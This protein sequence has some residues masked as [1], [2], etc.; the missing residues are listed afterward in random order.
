MKVI[1][2]GNTYEIF[3]DTLCTYDSLPP[4][5]YIA[6]FSEFKGFYLKKCGDIE[7][8]ENK[9]Y[10]THIGKVD[11]VLQSFKKFDRNL[12]VIMSGD[13]GIGKSLFAKLLSA[14]A[15]KRGIPVI[16]VDS[17][18][19]GISSF[20]ES[21]EQEIMVLFDEFDKTFKDS[22]AELLSLFDGI[23]TGKKLFVITC[24]EIYSLNEYLLNRPGRFHYHFRFE[25]PSP[26]EVR[27]YLQDKLPSEFYG[28]IDDVV[29]FSLKVNINYDCLRAIA[30]ELG[31][32]VPF[33]TAIKDLNIINN[34]DLR[35]IYTLTLHYANGM[36][37]TDE[38]R[39]L[40]LFDNEEQSFCFNDKNGNNLVCAECFL[41][42]AIFDIEKSEYVIQAQKLRITYFDTE[43]ESKEFMKLAE[44]TSVD[45]LTISCI[46]EKDSIHYSL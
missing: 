19:S 45:A 7:I 31:T 9:I 8:K 3:D 40:D 15:V 35:K 23:S 42:D 5:T 36:T 14:E 33:K 41:S 34:S 29:S 18:F 6:K 30:F 4:Q 37:V 1:S 44:K 24:N 20:L 12:G 43:D 21:I 10:G 28:E 46:P 11:K 27:A 16:I 39:F 17:Y 32:G 2:T 22:Q 25:Y 26:D 38:W 13:K